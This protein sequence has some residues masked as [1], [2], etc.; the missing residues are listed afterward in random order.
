LFKPGHPVFEVKSEWDAAG[1]VVRLRVAQV[2][3]FSKGV[4]V[5][6]VPVSIKLVTPAKTDIRKVWVREREETFEFPA[7]AKPLLVRFD[8]DNVLI[9]EV[10]FPKEREEL[11]Y[12]LKNDDVIGRMDAAAALLGYKDDP[13]T[14]AG[15]AAS[16]QNDPFW[17]VR[18]SSLE[19]LA[20]LKGKN[21]PAVFKKACQD[22]DSQVRAAAVSALG[23]LG[24]PGLLDFYMNLF[25]K[26]PS[27]RVQAE[28]LTA[29]G[30]T[31]DSAAIPFLKDAASLPSYRNMIR[32]AA[33]AAL[34]KLAKTGL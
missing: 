6:R 31:G 13:Q 27:Y 25:K 1:K 3:D 23:D 30:K 34:A 19:A 26:D 18:K 29:I 21:G 8:E 16:I 28:V 33:E 9:K 15:L 4:P 5:F 24:D 17:A 11:L 7:E 20:E 2:Q 12:Q 10:S 22:P 32:R 14:S